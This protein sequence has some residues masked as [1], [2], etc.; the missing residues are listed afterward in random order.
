[1]TAVKLDLPTAATTAEHRPDSTSVRPQSEPVQPADLPILR[2]VAE[3]EPEATLAPLSQRLGV[4]VGRMLDHLN[5]LHNKGFLT[6][7]LNKDWSWQ[8]SYALTDAGRAQLEA[9]S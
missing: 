1:M 2:A 8:R 4:S 3:L 7:R 9:A 5:T 6:A